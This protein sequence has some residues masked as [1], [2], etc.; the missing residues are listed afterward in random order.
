[1]APEYG[2]TFTKVLPHNSA[3]REAAKMIG[4]LLGAE[5]N[6]VPSGEVPEVP[7]VIRP[8]VIPST[9]L[10]R[11]A[12]AEDY[13]HQELA[14][15]I[16]QAFGGKLSG[17]TRLYE[18]GGS[19]VQNG[20]EANRWMT[21]PIWSPIVRRA[22]QREKVFI[23]KTIGRARSPQI[24]LFEYYGDIEFFRVRSVEQIAKAYGVSLHGAMFIKE[25][26][27]NQEVEEEDELSTPTSSHR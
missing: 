24:D 8:A 2:F 11:P 5:V 3:A 13:T 1:M 23:S 19:A 25:A 17:G 9:V 12:A 27:M 22:T 4:D 20:G 16:N 10:E 21:L 6:F 18:I 14:R 26:F 7:S 15:A